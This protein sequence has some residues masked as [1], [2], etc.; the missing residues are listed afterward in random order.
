MAMSQPACDI[1]VTEL[2]SE[3]AWDLKLL[4]EV[5]MQRLKQMRSQQ[6]RRQLVTGRSLLRTTLG[7]F[8]GLPDSEVDIVIGENGKPFCRNKG[9]P[10]F[11]LTH[12][13]NLVGLAVSTEM[14]GLD[15][16]HH[17]KGRDI[18]GIASTFFNPADL[19]VFM[20]QADSRSRLN[21][22]YTHWVTKEAISKISASG[23]FRELG[24]AGSKH[25]SQGA[26]VQSF[27][28][29]IGSDCWLGLAA[30]TDTALDVRINTSALAEHYQL[31]AIEITTGIS[32][33]SFGL[34]KLALEK[35]L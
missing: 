20:N 16:E 5:E 28:A 33:P 14:I 34:D 19:E 12:S 7:R 2:L 3:S 32:N 30:R 9:A 18:T 29:S 11:S 35:C 4:S 22:F 23:I 21:S 31:Q 10:C 26:A 13:R 1:H 24:N 25:D 8:L 15:I 6:K 27:S 17:R